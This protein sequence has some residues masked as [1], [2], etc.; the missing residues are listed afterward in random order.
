MEKKIVRLILGEKLIK[1]IKVY[2]KIV[3]ENVKKYNEHVSSH[4]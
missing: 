4:I 2:F 1:R 3:Y